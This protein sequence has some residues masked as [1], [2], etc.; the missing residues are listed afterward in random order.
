[1]AHA[2]VLAGPASTFD[3]QA[4]HYD[5]RVGLPEAVNAAVA[6]A[7]VEQANAG[8]DHLVVELGAGTGEIGVPLARFPVRYVGL[9][10]S[11]AMLNVFRTKA[12]DIS[13]SL[14]VA[15]CDR[16]WPLPDG[17]ATVVFGS[18][19][20]HL[21]RPDHVVR[22]TLRVCRPAGLLIIGRVLR[23][24][25]GI[26]ERLRRRRL[27]LLQE[28][29]FSPQQ[30]EA[31]TCRV[32]DGCVALGGA[33]LGRQ[34]VAEWT[35]ESTPGAILADWAS[36]ARWG[37]VVVNGST[38]AAMLEELWTWARSTFGDLDQPVVS[39]S[40]YAMDVVRLP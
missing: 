31:G 5:A 2:K 7:I 32:I 34:I 12:A 24:R 27:D 30:G 18:R 9:D 35:V 14:V 19:V 8:A 1:M 25:D 4:S 36:L 26:A 15:D 11:P 33:S 13:P 21:L 6:R 22:E 16:P 20:I 23:D 40:R 29:G 28:A 38:H 39:S 10:S 3:A 37:S 17:S